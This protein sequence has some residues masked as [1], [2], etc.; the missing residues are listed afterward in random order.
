MREKLKYVGY[1]LLW[2]LILI[3]TIWADGQAAKHRAAQSINALEIDVEGVEGHPLIDTLAM[4]EWIARHGLSPEGVSIERVAIADIERIVAEHAAVAESNVYVTFDGNLKV[5]VVQ[6]RPIARLR[7]DGYDAY[8]T[9]DGCILP[10]T[11]GYSVPVVVITGRYKPLFEASFS[12]YVEEVIRDS[13]ARLDENIAELERQKIPLFEQQ[14][15]NNKRLRL[16]LSQRVSRGYF[17][18]DDEYT[19]LRDEMNRRKSEARN[20]HR[21]RKQEIEAAIASLGRQ[22]ED[23]RHRQKLLQ[24]E[25]D[26][27]YA[28]LRFVT[29]VSQH[30]YWHSEIVQLIASGGSGKAIELSMI[31]RSGRFTVDLGTTEELWRKLSTLTR[32]YHEGLD[33]VGWDKFRHISLRYRGQVVCR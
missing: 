29:E 1:A 22:Q 28:M 14:Q 8:I 13:M 7:I 17:M 26:D 16:A 27:F 25:A 23:V 32:F 30:E 18:S 6:R 3:V 19:I 11:E 20:Y 10:A 5:D 4:K 15:E 21:Y 9:A 2:V 24:R 33:N 12:G 31:P